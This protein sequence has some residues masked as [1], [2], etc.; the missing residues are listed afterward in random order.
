MSF[1]VRIMVVKDTSC[2]LRNEQLNPPT[3]FSVIYF[4]GEVLQYFVLSMMCMQID[5]FLVFV[6]VTNVT[7]DDYEILFVAMR[8]CYEY[9]ITINWSSSKTGIF[10]FSCCRMCYEYVI[11]INW[12]YSKTGIFTSVDASVVRGHISYENVL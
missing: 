11:T 7:M 1:F 2:Y 8:M 4:K 5:T 6:I 9:V 3:P 12:S 10:T